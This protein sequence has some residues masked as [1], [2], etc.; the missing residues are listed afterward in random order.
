MYHTVHEIP[1]LAH[2]RA[3]SLYNLYSN[4]LSPPPF[5]NIRTPSLVF[6]KLLTDCCG[7]CWWGT[8]NTQASVQQAA[9][10][11]RG[12]D[13][14]NRK[15]ARSLLTCK[16]CIK[17]CFKNSPW[18]SAAAYSS[19]WCVYNSWHNF[20]GNLG[21]EDSES[22]GQWV[23]LRASLGAEAAG[24]CPRGQ[25]RQGSARATRRDKDRRP[26]WCR[27]PPVIADSA[28]TLKSNFHPKTWLLQ[29]LT[30]A[31]LYVFP[32][33]LFLEQLVT[34]SETHWSLLTGEDLFSLGM[35][36]KPT[37]DAVL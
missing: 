29:L 10:I 2:L 16:I 36:S 14:K 24:P 8:S 18:H 4:S 34:A 33:L 31:T 27:R 3:E 5:R 25:E 20:Q 6:P 17:S 11:N 15:L 9:F 26:T 19:F 23:G 35:P 22:P 28:L 1:K 21:G 30:L 13:R 12:P 37:G 7:S 32:L